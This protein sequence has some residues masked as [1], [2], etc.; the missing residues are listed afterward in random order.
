L[1]IDL[2][3]L[4]QLVLLHRIK[5]VEQHSPALFRAKGGRVLLLPYREVS[6]RPFPVVDVLAAVVVL[7]V[8][9]VD[10]GLCVELKIT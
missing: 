4:L 7:Q 5:D 2:H 6:L 8:D 9:D 1:L 10:R 3:A